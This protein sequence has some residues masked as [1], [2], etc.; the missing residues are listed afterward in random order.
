MNPYYT[1]ICVKN[2]DT[3]VCVKNKDTKLDNDFGGKLF[4]LNG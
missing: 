3:S 2:K 1:M 4:V